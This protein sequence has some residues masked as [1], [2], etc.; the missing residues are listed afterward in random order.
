M[1]PITEYGD[2]DRVSKSM[3]GKRGAKWSPRVPRKSAKYTQYTTPTEVKRMIKREIARN[4]ENKECNL[5]STLITITQSISDSD[6]VSLCPTI[7]QGVQ[8]GER[9]GNK[10]RVKRFNVRVAINVYNQAAAFSPCYVDVFIFKQRP[11]Q[12]Y[13]GVMPNIMDNFLQA[14]N[15]TVNYSGFVLDGLRDVNKDLFMLLY[16][17]RLLMYNPLN[18]TSVQGST[19]NIN[20]CETL[21]IDLTKYIR[22]LWEFNDENNEVTNENIWIAIGSTQTD[23]AIVTANIGRYAFMTNFEFEDA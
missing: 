18:G 1:D 20:P 6:L 12:S 5:E 7:K 14:G 3:S 19:S 4:V 2:K 8:Q 13:A 22:K 15:T 9:I 21:N 10:I 16:R 11:M 23:G 17:K